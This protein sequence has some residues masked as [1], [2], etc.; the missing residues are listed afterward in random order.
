MRKRFFVLVVFLFAGCGRRG[1]ELSTLSGD[2]LPLL[3]GR[4]VRCHN[5]QEKISGIALDR[6][7]NIMSSRPQKSMFPLVVP[8]SPDSSR[9]YRVIS[10]RDSSLVM[11]PPGL[12]IPRLNE[13][14]IDCIKR[15][16][17][18]GAKKN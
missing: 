4:C 15:W 18:Q 14:Q 16:I 12:G 5:E 13:E 11:P 8:F 10:S 9:L 1:V 3:G 2:V 6:Y 17:L 7:E